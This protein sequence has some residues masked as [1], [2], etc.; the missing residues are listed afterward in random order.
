MFALKDKKTGVFKRLCMIVALLLIITGCSN[1]NENLVAT[2]NGEEITKED[3]DSNYNVYKY[4]RERQLGEGALG[5]IGQDGKTLGEVLRNEILEELIM[6]KLISAEMAKVGITVTDEEI[7]LIYKDYELSM[8]GKENLENFL[9]ETNTSDEFFNR[10]LE[11]ISL[12]DKSRIQF[13]EGIHISEDEQREFFASHKDELTS[14]RAKHILVATEE[15]GNK[16]L[17]KI[18]G[19]E[20]F[21]NLAIMES[22]HV[23]SAVNGGDLGYFGRGDFIS[24]FED[25]AF[26][27]QV[28][29][30]SDLVKTEIGYH[31]IYLEDKKDDFEDLQEETIHVMKELKYLENREDLRLNAK[32]RKFVDLSQY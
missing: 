31:I 14:V 18:H 30:V 16:I 21:S 13:M 27:L 8:G 22:Q 9:K 29:E 10:F 20:D 24:E 4:F 1:N 6:E 19:G 26:N 5:Q 28:G 32:V 23:V 11:R 3:F 25:A 15:E 17:K 12:F 2:V 7:D